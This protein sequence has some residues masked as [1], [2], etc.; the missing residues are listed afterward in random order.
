MEKLKQSSDKK[1]LKKKAFLRLGNFLESERMTLCHPIILLVK[2]DSILILDQ[3]G[4]HQQG[5]LITYQQLIGKLMYPNCGTCLDIAFIVRQLS[6]HN[7]DPRAG[8][9]C[10]IK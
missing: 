5:D 8:Y 6:C 4:D 2:A 10:F 1:L 9:L 7:F 3:I